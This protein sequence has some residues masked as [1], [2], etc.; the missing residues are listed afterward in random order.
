M[1]SHFCPHNNLVWQAGRNY[2]GFNEEA[3]LEGLSTLLP[4]SE[5]GKQ[6]CSFGHGSQHW[7]WLW[8]EGII[9][10]TR[11]SLLVWPSSCNVD[12]LPASPRGITTW[13]FEEINSSILFF[14][15]F[16]F[17]CGKIHITQIIILAILCR[18]VQGHCVHLL[19]CAVPTTIIFRTLHAKR[20]FCTCTCWTTHALLLE[21]PHSHF[22]A[23]CLWTSLAN[24][25]KWLYPVLVSFVLIV[26][27]HLV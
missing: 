11:Q 9:W 3:G 12:C 26:L 8:G 2:P 10:G 20:K 1:W 19:C 5:P 6:G 7:V 21:P 27:F 13:P 22:P 25:F 16:F 23:F 15:I 17:Y 24:M 4:D 14:R 18:V